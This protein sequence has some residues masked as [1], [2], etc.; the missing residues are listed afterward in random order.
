MTFSP[1]YRFLNIQETPC[2]E[3]EF[4]HYS[5]P[6]KFP[7]MSTIEDHANWNISRE[8]GFNYCHTGLVRVK[9]CLLVSVLLCWSDTSTHYPMWFSL[10]SCHII[11]HV[12]PTQKVWGPI[13]FIFLLNMGVSNNEVIFSPLGSVMWLRVDI[14]NN[15]ISG[16]QSGA[17]N[18]KRGFP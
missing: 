1:L 6:V 7:D 9:M 13:R 15:V 17:A 10:K 16:T 4:D 5:S 14:P 11:V 18:Q 8:L 12:H 2:L 3:L